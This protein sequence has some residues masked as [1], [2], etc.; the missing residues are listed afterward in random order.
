MIPQSS[1][2]THIEVGVGSSFLKMFVGNAA[3]MMVSQLKLKLI[4]H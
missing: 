4:S 3:E 1:Q 2:A